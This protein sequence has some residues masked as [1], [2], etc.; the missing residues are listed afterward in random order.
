MWEIVEIS[1]LSLIGALCAWQ[2]QYYLALVRAGKKKQFSYLR[3]TLTIV[4]V[5]LLAGLV[6]EI[7]NRC[8]SSEW[9]TWISSTGLIFSFS[10]VYLILEKRAVEN[11]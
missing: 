5:L 6:G 11:T 3:Y 8:L 7:H 2:I 10:G 9:A 4:G 1:L